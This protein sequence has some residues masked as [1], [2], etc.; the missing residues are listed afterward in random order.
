MYIDDRSN[1][2]TDLALVDL[3]EMSVVTRITK[4]GLYTCGIAGTTGIKVILESVSG[5]YVNVFGRSIA[6]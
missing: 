5:G 4:P 2:Y 6:N 3:S 1:R